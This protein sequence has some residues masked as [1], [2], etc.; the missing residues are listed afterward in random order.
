VLICCK[1]PLKF[2]CDDWFIGLFVRIIQGLKTVV[3]CLA[4][5][6][7]VVLLAKPAEQERN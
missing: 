6:L 2:N 7:N 3:I 4:N 5:L 1:T